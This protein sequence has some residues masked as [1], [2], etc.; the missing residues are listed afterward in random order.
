MPD[1]PHSPTPQPPKSLSMNPRQST[2]AEPLTFL[3]AGIAEVVDGSQERPETQRLV[4]RDAQDVETVLD[5]VPDIRC[6]LHS[7]LLFVERER[8][9]VCV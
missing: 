7:L 3:D 1:A 8:E 6:T 2:R 5:E 9:S 4:L